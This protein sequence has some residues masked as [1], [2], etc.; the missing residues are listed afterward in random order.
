MNVALIEAC[1]C[2]TL[3]HVKWKKALTQR[4]W[5]KIKSTNK[6]LIFEKHASFIVLKA[7]IQSNK[8]FLSC[9]SE[10]GREPLHMMPLFRLEDAWKIM[11]SKESNPYRMK[12]FSSDFTFFFQDNNWEE[13]IAPVPT[14]RNEMANCYFQ[15]H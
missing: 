1:F 4:G 15:I 2:S 12:I 8:V 14:K 6:T 9:R 7:I 13:I 5:S 10:P 3:S 11:F